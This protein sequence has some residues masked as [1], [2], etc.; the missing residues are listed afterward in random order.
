MANATRLVKPVYRFNFALPME[1]ATKLQELSGKQK[2][3]MTAIVEEAL[4]MYFGYYAGI[5]HDEERWEKEHD[6]S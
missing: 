2:R 1:T 3:P 6:D 5:E 4:E